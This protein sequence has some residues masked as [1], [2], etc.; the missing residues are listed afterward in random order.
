MD[1]FQP[2]QVCRSHQ[3]VLLSASIPI[4][5]SPAANQIKRAKQEY[6]H[7]HGLTTRRISIM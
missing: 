7:N 1:E 5:A 3:T 2:Q 6:A 4:I